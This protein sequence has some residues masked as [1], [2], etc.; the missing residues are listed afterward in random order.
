M[1]NL[2]NINE[3][4]LLEVIK[5]NILI[6]NFSSSINNI[7]FKGSENPGTYYSYDVII[8]VRLVRFYSLYVC[9]YVGK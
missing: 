3:T 1:N 9:M 2:A 8:D 7:C 5:G 6:L 4:S